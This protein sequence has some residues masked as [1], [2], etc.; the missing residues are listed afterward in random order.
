MT[1]PLLVIDRADR[2]DRTAHSDLT[3]TLTADRKDVPHP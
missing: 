1:S 3:T 2:A